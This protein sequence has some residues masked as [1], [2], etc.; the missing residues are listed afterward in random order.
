MNDSQGR[1]G[2]L[3]T[4]ESSETG[5]GGTEPRNG[6]VPWASRGDKTTTSMSSSPEQG[7]PRL[8]HWRWPPYHHALLTG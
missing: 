5:A 8:P 4:A 7:S 2:A 6:S 3:E 1:E